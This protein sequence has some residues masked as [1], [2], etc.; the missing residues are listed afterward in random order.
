MREVLEFIKQAQTFF[1]ATVDGDAPRVRPFGAVMEHGGKI[2]ICMNNQKDVYKQL[3]QN[4]RIELCAF[5]GAGKWLRVAATVEFD[6]SAEAREAML[7][8]YPNLRNM[9]SADDGLYE[10]C[11]LKN[12]TATFYSFEGEPRAVTF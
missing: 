9:Y 10:V 11:F 5:D 6:D 4:P 12:A 3:A 1:A 8:E 2:Y 7:V